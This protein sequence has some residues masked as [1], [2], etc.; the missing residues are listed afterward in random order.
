MAFLPNLLRFI[1]NATTAP[2]AR[3]FEMIIP[4]L[5]FFS[6]DQLPITLTVSLMVLTSFHLGPNGLYLVFFPLNSWSAVDWGCVQSESEHGL[7]FIFVEFD[8]LPA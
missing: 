4:G 2:H 6:D 3:V 8:T 7:H 5:S 1:K